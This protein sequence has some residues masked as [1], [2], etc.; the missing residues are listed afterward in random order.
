M[1]KIFLLLIVALVSVSFLFVSC[2][3]TDDSLNKTLT[4]LTLTK[5]AYEK[6]VEFGCPYL[7]DKENYGTF[8]KLTNDI[9]VYW[10][11]S[12]DA[13]EVYLQNKDVKAQEEFLVNIEA[14]KDLVNK[15]T[16]Q[17]NFE[18]RY[19]LLLNGIISA[20]TVIAQS[21]VPNLKVVEKPEKSLD[22]LKICATCEELP[23]EMIKLDFS[24]AIKYPDF[25]KEWKEYIIKY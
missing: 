3:P 20:S 24:Y 15:V 16:E 23:K 11:L 17:F 9:K 1:R 2:K 25:P 14:F 18:D 12:I 7:Q 13:L 10:N 8:V 6:V 19:K 5:N 22:Y 21:L 4:Y